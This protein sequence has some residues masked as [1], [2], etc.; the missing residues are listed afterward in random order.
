MRVSVVTPHFNGSR[1]LSETGQSLLSQTHSDWEWIIIDDGSDQ[2]E[3]KA[4]DTLCKTDD[5]IKWH[6]RHGSPL[7]CL[8]TPTSPP[9]GT[10]V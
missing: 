2:E 1:F 6:P 9:S 10:H 8:Q 3:L 5:R 7:A 4:L